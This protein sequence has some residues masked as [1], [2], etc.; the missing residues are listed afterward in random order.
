MSMCV[1]GMNEE[2]REAGI[3][4]NA[5]WPRT[6]IATAAVKFALG[7]DNMMRVSRKDTIMSDAA[8]VI[9]TSNSETTT[10]N[11]FMDDEVLVSMGV[12][13]FSKYKIDPTVKDDDLAPDY[14]C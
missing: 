1:L 14:F 12:T 2:F 10:G 11:F 3:A 13:D 8:Y 9:L 5:L 7:G 4:V 6:A